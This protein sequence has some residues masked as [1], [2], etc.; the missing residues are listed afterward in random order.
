[1]R[2]SSSSVMGLSVSAVLTQYLRWLG[3][4]GILVFKAVKYKS[5]RAQI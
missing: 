2:G 1:M 3:P 5:A 4:L